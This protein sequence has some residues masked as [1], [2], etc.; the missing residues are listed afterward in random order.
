MYSYI[1]IYLCVRIYIYIYIYICFHLYIYIYTYLYSYVNIYIYLI[2]IVDARTRE[3]SA[4]LVWN[5]QDLW[6]A[7]LHEVL[8]ENSLKQTSHINHLRSKW[9]HY[10]SSSKITCV[11]PWN[12]VF[13]TQTTSEKTQTSW[14]H[15]KSKVFV[16][17]LHL[18]HPYPATPSNK[19]SHQ[20]RRQTFGDRTPEQ[21][22]GDGGTGALYENQRHSVFWRCDL[23]RY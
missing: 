9:I 3:I 4:S 15:N 1:Y 10:K 2:G 8:E 11:K 14:T 16:S 6:M 5:L 21:A 20:Q 17:I 12:I 7:Q 23:D 18:I 22:E 19:S 13:F